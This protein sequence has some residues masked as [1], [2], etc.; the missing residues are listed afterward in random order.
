[1]GGLGF[2]W[3]IALEHMTQLR[4]DGLSNTP[5]DLAAP[6]FSF[7]SIW[8]SVVVV[9]CCL[10]VHP[11]H[12]L[13]GPACKITWRHFLIETSLALDT[14]IINATNVETISGISLSAPAS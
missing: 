14:A 2:C 5:A 6:L 3:F 9:Y 7:F 8:L 11:I 1:M 13:Y 10:Q 4:L 12:A